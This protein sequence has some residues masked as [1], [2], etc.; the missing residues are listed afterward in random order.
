MDTV[1]D[2][3]LAVLALLKHLKVLR[4]SLPYGSKLGN[5]QKGHGIEFQNVEYSHLFSEGRWPVY[6]LMNMSKFRQYGV[7]STYIDDLML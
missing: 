4:R 3:V 2:V 5:P 6:R 1:F 7:E